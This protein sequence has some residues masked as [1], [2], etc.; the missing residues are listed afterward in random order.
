MNRSKVTILS[1][2]RQ[3][4]DTSLSLIQLAN[5]FK[6]FA[7]AAEDNKM[8]ALALIKRAEA[9]R[10]ELQYRPEVIDSEELS[11]QTNSAKEAYQQAIEK[12]DGD[13][14]LTAQAKY[15]IALCYEDLMQFDQA[16]TI[17][18]ELANDTDFA[19]TTAAAQAMMRWK[20]MDDYRQKLTFRPAPEPE[21]VTQETIDS[22]LV[23]P[24]APLPADVNEFN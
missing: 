22:E 11:M 9:L 8:A 12:A 24:Q 7:E 18:H 4:M 15:G 21:P 19:D 3:G 20:T 2:Q 23:A 17:Y 1:A 10:T 13:I 6:D 5:K 14:S 16:K